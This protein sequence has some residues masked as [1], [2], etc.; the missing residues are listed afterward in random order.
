MQ[1]YAKVLFSFGLTI[2]LGCNVP[3]GEL[4]EPSSEQ[5]SQDSSL[6]GELY[7]KSKKNRKNDEPKLFI[8]DTDI[9]S[10]VDDVGAIAMFGNFKGGKLIAMNAST[11]GRYADDALQVLNRHYRFGALVGQ[12]PKG[13]LVS[14]DPYAP[15]LSAEFPWKKSRPTYKS[16]RMY[17]KA[18]K[19]AESKV[20][21]VVIGSQKSISRLLDAERDLIK[22]KV[23]ELVVM[24][25]AFESS[26]HQ[27]W[28]IK[29]DV[30]AARNVAANWPTP[31]TYA[32][33]ELGVQ[34]FTGSH[35]KPENGPLYRAYQL[36]PGAGGVGRIGSSKSWDQIAVAYAMGNEN[37][38]ASKPIKIDFGSSGTT[39][40]SFD[41]NWKKRNPRRFLKFKD[42]NRVQKFITKKMQ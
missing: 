35:L 6:T 17:K 22:E 37:L 15:Q 42:K 19:N 24:G 16:I 3:K 31:I 38:R 36:Y 5:S 8:V 34:V 23:E 26:T 7:G 30:A 20:V 32:G 12:D 18:L 13:D 28:N 40:W 11:A 21:I 14:R 2:S 9:R 29:L 39:I 33:F 1:F 25:G 41:E 4:E 27:E 10:D